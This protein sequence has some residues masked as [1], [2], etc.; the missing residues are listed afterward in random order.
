MK[1]SV[2]NSEKW[3]EKG[4]ESPSEPEFS[5]SFQMDGARAGGSYVPALIIFAYS[6]P[7]FRTENTLQQKSSLKL[8][9]AIN[10]LILHLNIAFCFHGLKKFTILFCSCEK[11][12]CAPPPTPAQLAAAKASAASKASTRSIQRKE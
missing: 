1:K 5:S 8:N 9:S 3:H 4:H 2:L 6:S 12:K 10:Y 11:L 7:H